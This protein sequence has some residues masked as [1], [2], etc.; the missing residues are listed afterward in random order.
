MPYGRREGEDRPQR[1]TRGL[2]GKGGHS[3]MGKG[4]WW[5]RAISLGEPHGLPSEAIAHLFPSSPTAST[6]LGEEMGETRISF[7]A[8]RVVVSGTLAASIALPAR[9][10]TCLSP[11]T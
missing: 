4:G 11:S 2:Y 8:P 9:S 1:V 5:E 6:R 7:A 10:F 3:T